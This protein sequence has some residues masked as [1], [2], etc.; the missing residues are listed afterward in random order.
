[1]LPLLLYISILK[2]STHNGYVSTQIQIRKA[3]LQFY[4]DV[5]RSGIVVD[6][7]TVLTGTGSKLGSSKQITDASVQVQIL[8]E[9]NQSHLT[10]NEQQNEFVATF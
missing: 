5:L 4:G 1:M 2:L 7:L 9:M 6:G 3:V 10:L 8:N